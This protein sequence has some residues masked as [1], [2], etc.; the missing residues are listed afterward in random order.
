MDVYSPYFAGGFVQD[1]KMSWR[2]TCAV[3]VVGLG[4]AGAASA[5]QMNFEL[6]G[7]GAFGDNGAALQANLADATDVAYDAAGN[8]YVSQRNANRIRRIAPNGTITTIAGGNT[9]FAGDGGPAAAALIS[10]PAGLAIDGA[11]NL[12]FADSGNRRI[13]RITPAGVISTIAGNGG[14]GHAGDGGNALAASFATVNGLAVDPAGNVFVSDTPA[15]RV[16]RITPAGLIS[17]VAGTGEPAYTGDGGPGASASLNTPSGLDTDAAGNLYIADTLN[18]AVR[19]VTP[20]GVITSVWRVVQRFPTNIKTHGNALYISDATNCAVYLHNLGNSTVV[21]GGTC[22]VP[23]EGGTATTSR[24]GGPDG[25]AVDSLGQVVFVDTDFSR[26]RR[27]TNG[28]LLQT[29]AGVGGSFANGR[30]AIGA[31]LGNGYGLAV[32]AAG[33]VTF[34]DAGYARVRRINATGTVDTLAGMDGVWLGEQ[35]CAN[36]ATSCPGATLLLGAPSGIALGTAAGEV[37]FTDRVSDLIFSRNAAGTVTELAGGGGLAVG[38]DGPAN[39]VRI[40]PYGIARAPNGDLYFTD[41]RAN[42]VRRLNAGNVTTYVGMGD[43]SSAGDGG[44]AWFANVNRPVAIAIDPAGA[45]Y[46]S[47]GDGRRVRR[48]APDGKIATFAGNG[49]LGVSGD[50]G[51]AT[52]AAVG[53]VTGIAVN[54]GDVYLASEGALRRVRNGIITTVPG[55]TQFAVGL[56]ISNGRLYVATQQGGVYS[57]KLGRAT[58]SDY[59]G[60]G[61]SDILW[62]NNGSGANTIW[63]SANGA[64]PQTVTGVTNLAWKIV[65]QGDFDGDGKDDIFWRNAQ[66]GANTVWRSGNGATAITTTGVTDVGW[67]VVGVGDFDKDGKSDVVWRHKTNGKNVIWRSMAG[68]SIAVAPVGDLNWQIAGVGDFDG[69]G[70]AD[71][72]WRNNSTGA[73][74]IWRSGNNLTQL[75]VATAPA[76]WKLQGVGDFDGNGRS[77]LFFRNSSTGQDVI[78][79]G[80]N[81]GTP[82]TVNTVTDKYW[83]VAA[84]G[85]YD[86]DGKDDLLWRHAANGSNAIWRGGNAT[87]PQTVTGVT[88][89]AWAIVPYEFQP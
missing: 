32:D 72:V 8:L 34:S 29:I 59:D 77:D 67:T 19:Q 63:K 24:L 15:Q 43:P 14:R 50:G 36:N 73:N 54:G 79:N 48:V 82:R 60:D 30:A 68:A 51:A 33:N 58:A 87:Q 38:A 70:A 69:D 47:E 61:R 17:T 35:G 9:G 62:R 4:L 13:R 26:V 85:D 18:Q 83:K 45:M 42:K 86:G 64:T 2:T 57:A 66:T 75:A 23:N 37:I 88:N 81:A 28:G 7:G 55:F 31:P 27:V 80:A 25:V 74:Q 20:A 53:L 22:G 21:A 39:Q 44:Y 40:D 1:R 84:V 71:L 89:M 56:W 78:W 76:V 3:L 16:R 52:S 49:Q 41:Y 65:G 6:I 46:V 5:Q 12:Y 11:G 10:R